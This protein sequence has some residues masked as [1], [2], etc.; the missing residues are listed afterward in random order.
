MEIGTYFQFEVDLVA[1]EKSVVRAVDFIGPWRVMGDSVL[2]CDRLYG[3]QG[4][5]GFLLKVYRGTQHPFLELLPSSVGSKA[6]CQNLLSPNK[7]LPQQISLGLSQQ[8]IDSHCLC[9]LR[10]CINLAVI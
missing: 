5:C 1:L 10:C 8:N 7:P 6:P 2:D 9:N 3:F 4:V